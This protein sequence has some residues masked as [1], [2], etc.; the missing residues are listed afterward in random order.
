MGRRVPTCRECR[1][2]SGHDCRFTGCVAFARISILGPIGCFT[3]LAAARCPGRQQPAGARAGISFAPSVRAT[4]SSAVPVGQYRR[5][6]VV[7][8]LPPLVRAVLIYR[9]HTPTK[10]THQASC[11]AVPLTVRGCSASPVRVG[12]PFSCGIAVACSACE[13]FGRRCAV[14]LLP[15]SVLACS[16][17]QAP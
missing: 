4:P 7:A 13:L 2:S 6:C 12:C 11:M 15:P 17:R 9:Q 3:T 14:A 16:A 8:L 1:C 10:K 5:R